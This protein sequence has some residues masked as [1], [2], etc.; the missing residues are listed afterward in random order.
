MSVVC[1]SPQGRFRPPKFHRNF[2]EFVLVLRFLIIYVF[3]IT[4][5]AN[6]FFF[7]WFFLLSTRP[8]FFTF[9]LS[10]EIP[11]YGSPPRLLYILFKPLSE[12]ERR[13]VPPLNSITSSNAFGSSKSCFH[14]QQV[15]CT[16]SDYVTHES[17]CYL[18]A[19]AA[20]C[21]QLSREFPASKHAR[22]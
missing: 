20:R 1:D 7:F 6:F 17:D 9:N 3:V 22:R 15:K 12:F 18:N 4:T 13:R 5:N 14:D 2:R 21:V 11:G 16:K 8:V 10:T 19:A